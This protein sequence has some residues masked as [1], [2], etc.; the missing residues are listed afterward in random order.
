MDRNATQFRRKC[1]VVGRIVE[2][3]ISIQDLPIRLSK[4]CLEGMKLAKSVESL[5]VF[6]DRCEGGE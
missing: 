6:C 3:E 5:V 4:A 1:L 2:S